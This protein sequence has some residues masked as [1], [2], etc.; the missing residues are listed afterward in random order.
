MTG[1]DRA[2]LHLA[3]DQLARRPD[4]TQRNTPQCIDDE[5]RRSHRAPNSTSLLPASLARTYICRF[6]SPWSDPVNLPPT[7]SLA[8]RTYRRKPS[9]S[10]PLPDIP[11]VPPPRLT[12]RTRSS[13]FS[14]TESP[15]SDKSSAAS[16][17]NRTAVICNRPRQIE[18]SGVNERPTWTGGA[19]CCPLRMM[20]PR[21]LS[22]PLGR[23]A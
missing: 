22:A 13:S 3:E 14:P 12:T 17:G 10:D 4:R 5:P 20:L 6:R 18:S 1:T 9:L 8:I 23:I 11:R 2:A 7:G 16:P 19:Q 15:A 21:R